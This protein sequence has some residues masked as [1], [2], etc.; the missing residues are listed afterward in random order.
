VLIFS[1]IFPTCS[2][3]E[4]NIWREFLWAE[5]PTNN[6]DCWRSKRISCV[7]HFEHFFYLFLKL[8][9]GDTIQMFYV[10]SSP[11]LLVPILTEIIL[12]A[13]GKWHQLQHCRMI[14]W[15]SSIC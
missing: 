13:F 14:F 6:V 3:R 1:V 12:T 10:L 5:C 7:C 2:R 4:L 9:L 11:S 8:G 15:K